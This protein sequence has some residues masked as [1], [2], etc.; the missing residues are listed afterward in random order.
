MHFEKFVWKQIYLIYL[1]V[2]KF[3]SVKSGLP[4]LFQGLYYVYKIICIVLIANKIWYYKRLHLNVFIEML[5]DWVKVY[6]QILFFGQ[7][8]LL[9]Q[10]ISGHGD[11]LWLLPGKAGNIAS[12]EPHSV[13]DC[14]LNIGFWEGW[15]FSQ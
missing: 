6:G 14:Q 3:K 13:V 7:I 1:N 10:A 9:A 11:G 8:Y 5:L 4:N 2:N 12:G 15:E